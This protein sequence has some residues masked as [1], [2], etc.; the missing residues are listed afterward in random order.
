MVTNND[1][2]YLA[3]LI[4]ADPLQSNNLIQFVMCKMAMNI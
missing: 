1:S 4:W 2:Y 3:I